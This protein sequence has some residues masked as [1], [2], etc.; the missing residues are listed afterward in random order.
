MKKLYITVSVAF[1]SL[2]MMSFT[3]TTN[4]AN[5]NELTKADLVLEAE[6][7]SFEKFEEKRL[8]SDKTEWQKRHKTWTEF[9]FNKHISSL[10]DILERN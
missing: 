8:S 6:V 2:F 3:T 1:V 7:G 9:A 4:E 5:F 10:G